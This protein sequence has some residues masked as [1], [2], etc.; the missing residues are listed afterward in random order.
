MFEA[1]FHKATIFKKSMEVISSLIEIATL[2][3]SH[4]GI[5]MQCTD[6]SRTIFIRLKMYVRAFETFTCGKNLAL[7]IRM[8]SFV[9]ILKCANDNTVVTLT[10]GKDKD[11]DTLKVILKND[12]NK[13]EYTLRLLNIDFEE[14]GIPE[15]LPVN[16][17]AIL[18]S[19][20]FKRICTDINN[21]GNANIGLKFYN[22]KINIMSTGDEVNIDLDMLEGP[23]EAGGVQIETVD[24]SLDRLLYSA[25]YLYHFSRNQLDSNVR[26]S[27]IQDS[28]LRIK[29]DLNDGDGDIQFYIASMLFDEDL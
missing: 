25:K 11:P 10:T 20:E 24:D 5:S 8:A 26:M 1:C 22:D 19:S 9:K 15:H 2:E 23:T 6:A 14:Y 4:E 27:I 7:G 18:P 16:N 29:Y 3:I 17:D 21:M 13:S 28:L 12:R